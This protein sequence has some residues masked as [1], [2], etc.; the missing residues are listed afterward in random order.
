[1]SAQAQPEM[2]T[3]KSHFWAKALSNPEIQLGKRK[4]ENAPP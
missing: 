3:G 1:M 2:F 4:R